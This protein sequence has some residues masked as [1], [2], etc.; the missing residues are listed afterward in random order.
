MDQTRIGLVA[1]PQ[2]EK[3]A[4]NAARLLKLFSDR[5]AKVIL[6]TETA[7][8]IEERGQPVKDV[9]ESSDIVVLLGGDG[10]ILQLA[11]N[12]GAGVKP[13][14]AIN[15]G[16][17]GF[18]TLATTDDLEGVVDM[19]MRKNYLISKRS[20]ISA[21]TYVGKKLKSRHFALN[22]MVVGRGRISRL[23]KVQAR[24]NGQEVSCFN[25]DGLIISTPT[26]STAYSLSA[27]GPLIEPEARVFIVNPVCAHSLSTRP[28]VVSD[29]SVIEIEA[30]EQRDEVFVTYDGQATET[31]KPGMRIVVKQAR[32]KVPLI[33]AP[34]STFY[35]VLRQKLDWSGNNNY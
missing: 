11:Q 19:L 23:V 17:L 31:I 13:I 5:G 18:L 35:S 28:V 33:C 3:A 20:V 22:E 2:K 34:D 32:H 21:R 16:T 4:E 10:T 27:G 7:G 14:A 12:M 9:V 26:G 1:N 30:P 15:I 25:G 24:I 8:L 6:E 29:Q